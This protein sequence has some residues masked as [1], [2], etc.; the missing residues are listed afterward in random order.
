MNYTDLKIGQKVFFI[1]A[2][3]ENHKAEEVLITKINKD[4]TFL[5]ERNGIDICCVI[6]ND[7]DIFNFA[8]SDE[9]DSQKYGILYLNLELII[10]E[11][12]FHNMIYENIAEIESLS[13]KNKIKLTTFLEELLGK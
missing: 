1:S 9:E 5:I 13:V 10:Q 4:N 3:D 8:Y 6:E 11:E 12:K 2:I 7:S